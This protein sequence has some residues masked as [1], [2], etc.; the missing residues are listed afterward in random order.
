MSPSPSPILR[1]AALACPLALAPL[2]ASESESH[3]AQPP[4]AAATAAEPEHAHGHE[5]ANA[6]PAKPAANVADASTAAAPSKAPAPASADTRDQRAAEYAGLMRI[7]EKKLSAKDHE[8]AI[9]AAREAVR[10]AKGE[11]AAPALLNL[12]RAYRIAGDGVKCTAT[13]EHLLDRF[14]D[15]SGVPVALLELGRALRELGAPQLAIARFYSVIQSTLRLPEAETEHYRRLVRTAQFEIA[16]TH[17][18]SGNTAD[19]IRFFRRL[20]A[21]DLAPADRARGRFRTAQAQLL[22]GDRAAAIVTIG[23]L[24]AQDP[25]AA[26]AAEARFT[27]A[28]L[29]AEG[30]RSDEALRVTLE[31]LRSTSE[32]GDPAAWREWQRRAGNFLA[33]RFKDEGETHSALLLYRALALLDASPAWR[34]PALYEAG[35]CLEQLQQ[36]AEARAT[37]D[38]LVDLIA[39]APEPGPAESELQRMAKWR[40]DQLE[41]AGRTEDQIRRLSPVTGRVSLKPPP[42]S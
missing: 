13:Y 24:L 1:L 39:K 4:I 10:L 8:A 6:E 9:F 11:E 42:T 31:L 23:R 33:R 19:A 26:E 38:E 29:H 12:A 27:L 18:Q 5:P 22:S 20:D 40:G 32:A 36:P 2:H 41:W 28:K 14:P 7:S 15:W 3:A 30:G 37:Y 25:G 16:E 17:F 34:A 35:L 21:L